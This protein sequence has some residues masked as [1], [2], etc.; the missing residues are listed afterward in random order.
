MGGAIARHIARA[1]HD[2]TI[3][4]RS[5]EQAA[6]WIAA[7]GGRSAATPAQAAQDAE[8]VLACVGADAD[9]RERLV[10][11][12]EQLYK[13]QL[14]AGSMLERTLALYQRCLASAT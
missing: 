11:G 7:H 2:L 6:A 8:V 14:T 3:Y 12:G 4:N 10:A 5:P 9:L 1:G 13:T